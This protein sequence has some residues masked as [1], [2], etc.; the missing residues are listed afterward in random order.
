MKE[1]TDSALLRERGNSFHS[2]GAKKA[3]ALSPFVLSFVLG[4]LSRSFP[5]DLRALTF[6]F[7]SSSSLMYGGDR[8]CRALKVINKILKTILESIGSQCKAARTGVMW[9]LLKV[10]VKSLAAAF[11]TNWRRCI[12]E[13]VRVVNKELQ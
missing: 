7:G 9:D 13:R 10:L 1:F 2:V 12:Q 8:P 4:T 6:T 3:K 11:C 5:E